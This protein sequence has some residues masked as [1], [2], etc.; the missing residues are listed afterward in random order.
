MSSRRMCETCEYFPELKELPKCRKGIHMPR[1][2]D[3][4]GDTHYSVPGCRYYEP[5]KLVFHFEKFPGN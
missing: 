5:D 2:R 1:Y 4:T 3:F